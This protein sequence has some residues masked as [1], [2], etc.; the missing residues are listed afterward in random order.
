[1]LE[2]AK[3]TM[4]HESSEV[5]DVSVDETASLGYVA[6]AKGNEVD[7]ESVGG[8]DNPLITSEFATECSGRNIENG[9]LSK[10]SR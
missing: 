6:C 8:E 9:S 3:P 5:N 4:S 7:N 1:M 10:L 2:F